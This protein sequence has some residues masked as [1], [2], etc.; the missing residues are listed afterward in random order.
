MK[1]N[2]VPAAGAQWVRAG[3]R[4]FFRRPVALTGLFFMFMAALS[5]VVIVPVVGGIVA[6]VLVPAGAS[7]GSLPA[8]S[9]ARCST[10]PRPLCADRLAPTARS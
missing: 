9:L 4:T 7:L 2:V 1:L 10:L 8:T 3:I 6:L 5:L